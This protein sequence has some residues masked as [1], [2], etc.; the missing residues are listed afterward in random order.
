MGGELDRAELVADPARDDDSLT[1]RPPLDDHS[2]APVRGLTG[3][4]PTLDRPIGRAHVCLM[5]VQPPGIAADAARKALP[6]NQ[7]ARIGSMFLPRFRV[8]RAAARFLAALFVV[9]G[10]VGCSATPGATAPAAT[11][12]GATAPLAATPVA[13]WPVSPEPLPEAT[14]G[15]AEAG[16]TCG[17]RTFPASGLEA[18]TGAEKASGPEFDA[19]RATLAK[20]ASEFPGASGWSWRLAGRDASDATFLAQSNALE[21]PVWVSVEVTTGANGW[22]PGSMGQCNLRVVLSAEYGPA[23]WALDPAFPAPTADT[24]ELHLLV[25]EI[26]CSSGSPATGRMSAPVIESTSSTVTITIGVRPLPA[27]PGTAFSCPMPKGTPASLRLAEPL[28][29]RTLLDG[30]TVPPAPPSPAFG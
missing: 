10:L 9:L 14:S 6:A 11:T 23:S 28:G 12:P 20:L 1:G 17:G 21:P 2:A 26:A 19:L 8:R 5:G 18:P 16:L 15:S 24:T 30:G 22:Q 29:K 27:A 25:W 13:T 7:V 4:F 3:T